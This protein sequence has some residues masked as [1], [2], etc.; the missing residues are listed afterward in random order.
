MAK[1]SESA[2]SADG[3]KAVARFTVQ[4]PD[5]LRAE[6]DQIKSAMSEAVRST[7]GLPFEASNAQVVSALI[8]ARA[9]ELRAVAEPAPA[10]G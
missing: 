1:S 5:E 4:L 6:L 10:G 2:A 8:K 3:G 7:T 9:G